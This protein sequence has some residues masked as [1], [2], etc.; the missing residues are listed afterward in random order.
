MKKMK[1]IEFW[2]KKEEEAFALLQTHVVWPDI[3][4]PARLDDK[5]HADL[6]VLSPKHTSTSKSQGM[7]RSS[8]SSSGGRAGEILLPIHG[9]S[10]P[11]YV[12]DS[13][14]D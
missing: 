11:C 13:S 3:E 10:Y 12:I 2:R 5:I 6:K 1:E 14:S 9:Q 7:K 4:G 8:S